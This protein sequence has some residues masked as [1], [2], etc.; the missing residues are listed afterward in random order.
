ML[1]FGCFLG[2]DARD[3]RPICPSPS[4]RHSYER[5]RLFTDLKN[6]SQKIRRNFT[7]TSVKN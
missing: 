4:A 2:L 3:Y 1:L 5:N 6:R 7:K